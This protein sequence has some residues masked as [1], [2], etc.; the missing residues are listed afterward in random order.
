MWTFALFLNVSNSFLA[1]KWHITNTSM[2]S[3]FICPFPTGASKASFPGN[4][5]KY[6]STAQSA[7]S[8]TLTT[9]P[10]AFVPKEQSFS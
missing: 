10:T 7:L 9:E 4:E 8:L 6:D 5:L 2:K 3:C 1:G